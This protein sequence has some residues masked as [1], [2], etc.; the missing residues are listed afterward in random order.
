MDEHELKEL[1][2]K[3]LAETATPEEEK[4]LLDW[5]HES[6]NS[7]ATILFSSEKEKELLFSR[8]RKKL[9][10]YIDKDRIPRR[11]VRRM[12][13][14]PVAVASVVL[15]FAVGGYLIYLNY[16]QHIAVPLHT[17]AKHDVM[18]GGNKAVLTLADGSTVV[19][20]DVKNGQIAQQ[21]NALVKKTADGQLVYTTGYPDK[22]QNLYPPAI[23]T[24]TTP[25]GGQYHLILSDGTQV[26]LN[27]AS[28]INYPAAFTGKSREVSV[29][30]EAYF[31]VVHNS[32]APFVVHTKG[33][34]VKDLGTQFNINA[35]DDEP[36]IKTT[37]VEG[38][39][40]LST[41]HSP[42]S[43]VLNPGERAVVNK[44]GTIDKETD[45]DLEHTVA[46]KNNL[47]IFSGDDIQ[48]VMRQLS[49]WYQVE[50]AYQGDRS[51]RHFSGIISR[52][53]NISAVLKM[54]EATEKVKFRID[55]NKIIVSFQ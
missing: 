33:I 22:T 7:E 53:N 12:V 40:K 42:L 5:Y 26:W 8:V 29:T 20:S 51:S 21:G 19:L 14:R 4:K 30:G 38:S 44:Q 32:E 36:A 2:D 47:F 18:P 16:R 43:I 41:V 13:Y 3:Y 48:T 55:G 10:S 52:N 9:E 31:E 25:R 23:N 34:S 11:S 15:L 54:L 46:W 45:V 35:Y 17:T 1:I 37:L 50:V 6:D 28:S 24:I 49:R 39:V 27:A